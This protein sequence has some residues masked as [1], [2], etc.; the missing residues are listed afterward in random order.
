MENAAS[1][2]IA[3][4]VNTYKLAVKNLLDST[5]SGEPNI[6][7]GKALVDAG[8]CLQSLIVLTGTVGSGGMESIDYGSLLKEFQ[9]DE[10]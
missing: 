9:Q 3:A 7:L 5:E 6:V 8:K 2:D 1:N 4:M 10:N